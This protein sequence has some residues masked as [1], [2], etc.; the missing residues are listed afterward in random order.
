M[1]S[2]S[3]EDHQRMIFKYKEDLMLKYKEETSGGQSFTD[4]PSELIS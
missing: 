2:Q 1:V 4:F 3:K